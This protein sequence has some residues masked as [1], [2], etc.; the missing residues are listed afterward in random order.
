[1]STPESQDYEANLARLQ[2]VVEKLEGE[3]MGLEE[4]LKLF[5]EG[6]QLSQKCD[7]QLK[8]VEDR[9]QVLVSG[10]ENLS[11]R[12]DI[13]IQPVPIDKETEYTDAKFDAR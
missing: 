4:S 8:W 1:M 2:Q 9:V 3:A 13:P 12:A 5:E 6:I 7:Q 10:S 11:T